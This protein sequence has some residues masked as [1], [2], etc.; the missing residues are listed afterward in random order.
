MGKWIAVGRIAKSHGLKGEMKFRTT[1]PDPKIVQSLSRICLG[2]EGKGPGD[3]I[4]EKFGVRGH[5]SKLILKLPGVDSVEMAK[6]L[7]GQTVFCAREDFPEL[8]KGE[9][10][11]FE[12]I[13]LKVFNEEGQ[14]F[15]EV[16]EILN[17]AS[18]DIYVVRDNNREIMLPAVGEVVKTVDLAQGRLVFHQIEGM[19][20]DSAV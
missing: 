20:E 3:K 18:S 5:F 7:T 6:S 13:G 12:I 17:T 10:Y 4:Y 9:H 16:E 1:V 2:A 19:I 15:G 11:W 14:C 8:P